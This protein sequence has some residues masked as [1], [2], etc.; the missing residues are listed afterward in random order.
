MT[1]QV[2]C[3][4]TLDTFQ[5]YVWAVKT[6]RL[7]EVL[8]AHEGPIAQLSF[9]PTQS[10]LAS[11]SWDH[12]VRTWDVFRYTPLQSCLLANLPH[13]ASIRMKCF[14]MRLSTRP[15]FS[16]RALPSYSCLPSQCE[17][18]WVAISRLLLC[19]GK[20][21]VDL[22]Q[23]DHDVLA[24]AFRPDGKLLASATLDAQILFW[25]PEEGELQVRELHV[26]SSRPLTA[27]CC[28]AAADIFTEISE[29]SQ[30]TAR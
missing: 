28:S 21:G 24:V 23:H 5:I 8:A 17:P 19:S 4:G 6:G 13:A 20:G 29:Q 3:A 2:V 12:T 7:L 27:A 26:K 15:N 1:V 16:C 9:S 25:D 22:L 30:P 11:C 10:L 18:G 14:N